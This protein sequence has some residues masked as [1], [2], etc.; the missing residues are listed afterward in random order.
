MLETGRTLIT[1]PI[2]GSSKKLEKI[3]DTN[4]ITVT[5]LQER[6]D[7]FEVEVAGKPTTLKRLRS[8]IQPAKPRSCLDQLDEVMYTYSPTNAWR[9]R[10]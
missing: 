5:R 4:G 6:G 2:D 9:E 3:A 8:E 7:S 10:K 1:I